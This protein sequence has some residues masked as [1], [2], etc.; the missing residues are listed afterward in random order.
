MFHVRSACSS[1]GV[2]PDMSG[3]MCAYIG[4]NHEGK[5]CS[6]AL[7]HNIHV[8][9]KRMT[10][11]ILHGGT[12]TGAN[13]SNFQKNRGGFGADWSLFRAYR[14]RAKQKLPRKEPFWPDWR[15]FGQALM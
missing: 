14:L 8:M 7:F 11:K 15:L 2:Y 9:P 5:L 13:T 6:G 1:G 10:L 3:Y 4:F 12:Q